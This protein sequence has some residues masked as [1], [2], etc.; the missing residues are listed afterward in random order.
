MAQC[1][2]NY[3][4]SWDEK[5][6]SKEECGKKHHRVESVHVLRSCP[7]AQGRDG[8]PFPTLM[9]YKRAWVKFSNGFL[10]LAYFFSFLLMCRR[11]CHQ[12]RQ[13]GARLRAACVR[14]LNDSS[15]FVFS[16]CS[17]MGEEQAEWCVRKGRY[18]LWTC[19]LHKRSALHKWRF[20]IFS[21]YCDLCRL[22]AHI[23]EQNTLSICR[24]NIPTL[25]KL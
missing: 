5:I 25:S 20:N 15:E 4:Y 1:L 7:E 21:V 13:D 11:Q 14:L 2:I 9:L 18:V 17:E 19:G 24:A 6:L 10:S 23:P 16:H 8:D 22:S 3:I 12:P